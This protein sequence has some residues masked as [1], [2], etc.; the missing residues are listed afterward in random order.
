MLMKQMPMKVCWTQMFVEE[1]K[2][3]FDWLKK[4]E[5]IEEKISSFLPFWLHLASFLCYW[6]RNIRKQHSLL[7]KDLS[8]SVC[9]FGCFYLCRSAASSVFCGCFR[10]SARFR[11]VLPRP[12]PTAASTAPP[13]A[14]SCLLSAHQNT[15]AARLLKHRC[16]L[17]IRLDR[18]EKSL[19]CRLECT[20]SQCWLAVQT[21]TAKQSQ[22]C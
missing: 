5:L 14:S 17:R 19:C 10:R 3:E 1:E 22:K 6:H 13:A 18:T 11:R 20:R 8:D 9:L 7:G 21:E 15:T 16:L 12:V 2:E 4:D